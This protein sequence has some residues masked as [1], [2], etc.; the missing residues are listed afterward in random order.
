LDPAFRWNGTSQRSSF[1]IGPSFYYYRFDKDD[2]TGRFINNTSLIGSY[3][4]ATTDK[5]KSH[6]GIALRFTNDRRN[7]TVLPQWGSFINIRV[8]GYKGLGNFAKSY[9]QFI[10]EIILYKNINT[11]S[12]VIIAERIGGTFSIGQPA[13]YQS[14]YIGGHENLLGYRQYRFAGRHS[15]YNNLELRIKL[16][17]FAG[18]IVP[19]QFGITGFWDAGRVWEKHD[20]S[21]KWHH[22]TGGGIYFAPASILAFSFVMGHSSE[23]W[24]PYFSMGLR[25]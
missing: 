9:A 24:Y 23:G 4:S 1:S 17:D 15:I 21:G 5:A 8:V 22:G 2:N 25:F 14:A 3:D 11:R 20:N 18:Y 6:L 12:T 10:P 13:F 7:N 19:G 16:A